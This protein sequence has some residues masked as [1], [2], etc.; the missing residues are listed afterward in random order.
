MSD[1]SQAKDEFGLTK[2]LSAYHH[3]SKL[4]TTIIKEEMIKEGK[5]TSLGEIVSVVSSRWKKLNDVEREKYEILAKQDRERYNAECAI[6]DEEV[7]RQQEERRKQNS[8]T[9]T[10]TRMRGSTMASSDAV[11]S[12]ADVPKKTR[13]ISQDERRQI[14]ERRQIRND[15]ECIMKLQHD[16]VK[17]AKAQQAEARLKY[18]LSQSDIFAHFGVG[19]KDGGISK[20]PAGESSS[21]GRRSRTSTTSE[22]DLDEDELAM[23]NDEFDDDEYV[24]EASKVKH[25]QPAVLKKQ[26]SII[27][28]GELRYLSSLAFTFIILNYIFI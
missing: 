8:M 22:V 18:L 16:D 10:E 7:Y 17:A 23:V 9:E 24:A 21:P 13:H 20:P 5:C 25:Q 14:E 26:P 3:Y 11:V 2:N 12:K 6:R 19:R 15:E 4:N 1:E 28:G 27:T